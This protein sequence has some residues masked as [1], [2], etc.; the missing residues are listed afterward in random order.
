MSNP[1]REPFAESSLI[2]LLRGRALEHPERPAYTFLADGEEEGG[3][4]TFAELDAQARALGA[5]LQRLGLAGQ[6][7]LLLYPPGLEFVSAFLG[8]L[9]GGV[10]AVPAYPPRSERMLPRLRSI[11]RDARPAVALTTSDLRAR[12]EALAGRLP[13]MAGAQWLATDGL[14]AA[15]LAEEWEE[16]EID[17]DTLAFLQYTS[18]STAQPKGVMVTHGN[19]LHNEEMIQAAFAQSERSLIVGWLPLYHDM[20]LIGNVLQPLYVGAS[21]V[22]MSPVAFL[23]RPARWLRAISRYRGTTSGG[24]NFAYELCVRKIPPAERHG[25]DL[26]SW[27]VAFNGAEPVRAETLERFAA[28]FAPCGFRREAFYPCYGLAEATLFVSGGAA[29][30]GPAVG[31]FRPAD[32]EL[33]QVAATAA[34]DPAGRRLVGCGRAWSETEIAIVDPATGRR[35]APDR[36]GEIWVAGPSVAAG[37][38]DNPAE[39]AR[40]FQARLAGETGEAGGPFLRT[41]DLGFL[42]EGSLFVTGR[43]KDLIILRGRNHYPQ[44]LEATAEESHPALRAGASAAFAVDAAGE[45]RLV[46]VAELERRREAEAGAAAEAVRRAVAEAHEVRVHEVVLVRAGTIPTTSSGKIQRHATRDGYLAGELTVVGRSALD[47]DDRDERGEREDEDAGESPAAGLD[48]EALA[49]LPVEERRTAL[50]AWLRAEAA[51]SLGVPAAGLEMDRPLTAF[52]LDS[53]AAIELRARAESVLGLNLPLGGLL[54]GAT[55]AELAA[56]AMAE[57]A[58]PVPALPATGGPSASGEETGVFPLS[59][60]QRS[61]WFL[62]RLAPESLAYHL[63]GVARVRGPLDFDALTRAAEALAERHPALRTTFAEGPAGPEQTV[64]ARLAPEV[65]FGDAEG[66]S[67]NETAARLRAEIWRP[68]DLGRGPLVRLGALRRGPAET[69]LFLAIHHIVSDFWSL[70]VMA[71]DLGAF[72]ARETG[73]PAAAPPA[74]ELRYTDWSRW[75]RERLAGPEGERLWEGWREILAGDPQRLELPTDRPWPAAQTWEGGARVFRLDGAAAG[76]L[77]ALARRRG[78]TLFMGL[79]A[80]FEALLARYTGQEEILLGSPTAG[81]SAEVADLVGY[82]V[83]PVAIRARLGDDPAFLDVLGETRRAVVAAFERQDYPF[84]LLA[85]RLQPGRDA[86][87]PPLFDVVFAF[88]KARGVEDG[89]GGFALGEGGARL[90]LG[91]LEL[92]SLPLAPAGAPFALS[93][94]LAETAGGIG[95]ALRFN[96]SLFDAA[97][98]DRLAGHYLTLLAGA[99]TDPGRRLSEMPLL[100]GEE[101]WQLVAEWNETAAWYSRDT[102]VHRLAAVWAE[103]APDAP[104]VGPLSYGEL[105]DRAGRVAGWLRRQGVGPEIRVPV[106]LDRSAELAVAVLAVLEAGGAYVP[107]DP[108][109]P[110]ERLAWQ[111]ED[112]WAGSPVRALLTRSELAESLGVRDARTLCVDRGLERLA[113]WGEPPLPVPAERAAYVIYTSGST[114][115]PKGVV[116]S[117]GALANLVEWHCHTYRVAASDRAA[118][119]A[120]PGFDASVWE[121]WPYLAAG[122]SLRVP[123]EEIRSAPDRLVRWLAAEGITIAFL[124]TPLAEAALAESW[125]QQTRLRILLTGGDRLRRGPRPGLPFILHNHYGPTEGAVVATAAPVAPE[126]SAPSIGRPIANARVHVLDRWQRLAPVGV[127]GELLLGGDGLARG[128]LHRPNLTA[129]AF[130]P[131]PFAEEAGCR[132]YR[133]GD[134]VRWTPEGSLE[135]L[136]RIDRQVKVRGFR[137]ELGEIEAALCELPG[138]R[139][140]VVEVRSVGSVGSSDPIGRRPAGRLRGGGGRGGGAARVPARPAARGHDPHGL[141]LPGGPAADAQRQGGPQ[142][143]ARA[144][145]RGRLDRAADARRGKAGRRLGRGAGDRAGRRR[146]RLLRPRRPLAAGGAGGLAGERGLRDRAAARPAVRGADPGRPGRR[147]RGAGD[148]G[149]AAA[150]ARHGGGERGGPAPL[151]RPGAVLAAGPPGAGLGGLQHRGRRAAAR[152]AGRT[153]PVPGPGRDRPPS[154][155][156]AHPLRGGPRAAG[157]AAAGAGAAG[158][159]RL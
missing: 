53:L 72:Y 92:E 61:L 120:G 65:L 34:L 31:S 129:A 50:E 151:L 80:A 8:C 137:V 100:T 74:L 139:Q 159:R 22:L 144:G 127:P 73:R 98:M 1:L 91:G 124:P 109:N 35:C 112:A 20:G 158:L 37:Y 5:R 84:A 131:D 82:F 123:T 102:A 48:R 88:E 58:S 62:H 113:P 23:Q 115:K 29:G 121:M 152:G 141:G 83:N 75:R 147:D 133:T 130:V 85:E 59:H 16:P 90:R 153:G 25:L 122:A 119:V 143:P 47:R 111:L 49:A 11:A 56:G 114:G 57:L 46:V 36:V 81:R 89:L 96:S 78:A 39:T 150:A 128:Y 12:V 77:Q 41:G 71:R 2:Q 107:L 101:E 76:D 43:L 64:H 103:A 126:R 27:Q 105:V 145:R 79:L 99:V 70:A 154:P 148:G 157:A 104:A 93:L 17:G 7:A 86:A 135:F 26:S 66:W 95:A 155:G 45:E 51:R 13:E 21:C 63:A 69:L 3:R 19:L 33:G 44:D 138:V 32:L 97:T 38:W 60:G 6:R 116:I 54:E 30:A 87:R 134:L 67:E 9:Y 68:F 18:G 108:A 28:A 14:D 24:P 140:A 125:P 149:G 146:G 117:H 110:A 52:G 118:L 40:T 10:V 132:L 156:A 106:V 4:L 55:L 142:G 136:G 94:I 15:G 42:R